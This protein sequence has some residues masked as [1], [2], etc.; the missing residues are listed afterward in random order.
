MKTSWIK[1][2]LPSFLSIYLLVIF[3]TDYSLVGFWTDVVVSILLCVFCWRLVFSKKF[4]DKW[5]DMILKF[6]TITSSVI[7]GG[8]MFLTLLNPFSIDTLKLRSFY[9]QTVQERTFHAY[10][11]PVGAYSGGQG[12]FW[13]TESLP[14][15]PI[16]EKEVHYNR[17]VH[18]DFG[19]DV[20]DGEMIDNYEE[21]RRY[22]GSRIMKKEF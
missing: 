12:N 13:I 17:T 20:F 2:I 9:F 5:S 14:F 18:H 1:I 22:I 16:I 21:V 6:L 15:F 8:I 11:K 19:N 4:E 3:K 10:F 7:V